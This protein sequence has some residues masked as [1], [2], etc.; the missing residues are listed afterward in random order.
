MVSDYSS[1]CPP[2]I[3]LTWSCKDAAVMSD[4]SYEHILGAR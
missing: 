2:A 3:D 4:A 1:D